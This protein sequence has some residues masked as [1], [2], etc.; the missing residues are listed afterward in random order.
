MRMVAS[1]GAVALMVGPLPAQVN[2]KKPFDDATF[3][4]A[5]A[6]GGLLEVEL[7]K[8]ASDKVRM[9][10]V[11]KF[12]DRMVTDHGKANEALKTAARAAN[13]PVPDKMNDEHQKAYDRFKSYTGTDFDRDYIR[14]MVKDHEEDV[15]AFARAAKE[16]KNPQIKDFAAATLPVIQEHLKMAK[17]L[18]DQR[19]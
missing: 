2:E 16:A 4:A 3:V 5:A 13:I 1:L 19:N 8:L 10:S 12:A 15:A 7:G 9:D 17:Q 14:F 11:K 18:F 6:S